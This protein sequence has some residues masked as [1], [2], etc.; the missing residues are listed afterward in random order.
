MWHLRYP[1]TGRDRHHCR[2]CP[3]GRGAKGGRFTSKLR[4][5]ACGNGGDASGFGAKGAHA[6]SIVDGIAFIKD[7]IVAREGERVGVCERCAW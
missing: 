4:E 7:R 5:H 6:G 1:A 3:N 2:V